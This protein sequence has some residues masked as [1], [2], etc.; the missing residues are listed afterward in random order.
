MSFPCLLK[1]VCLE[2]H[3]QVQGLQIPYQYLSNLEKMTYPDC[4]VKPQKEQGSSKWE[5]RL[6]T[7]IECQEHICKTYT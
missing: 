7:G 1:E 3:Y 5:F 4:K 6:W 2:T